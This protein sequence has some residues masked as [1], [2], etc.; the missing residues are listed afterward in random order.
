MAYDEEL[1]RRIIAIVSGWGATRKKMFGT[2]CHLLNGNMLGGVYNDLVIIRLGVDEARKALEM[3]YI[4][5]FDITGKPMKGW[6][7][8][9]EQGVQGEELARWLRRARDFVNTMPPK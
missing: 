7:L 3:P 6:I 8:I 1:D 4:R 5:P 2:T 9:E